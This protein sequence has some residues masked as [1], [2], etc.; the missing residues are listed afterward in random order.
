MPV[1]D[2]QDNSL[3]QLR[4]MLRNRNLKPQVGDFVVRKD[5][6]HKRIAYL[7]GDEAI[8]LA[9]GGSFYLCD[10]GDA[11]YSGSLD[12]GIPPKLEL[13][14]EVRSGEFWVFH[15]D[16][17]LAH[18]G[19]T[20]SIPCRVYRLLEGAMWK[21]VLT[22]D[23][24]EV[25]IGDRV[26]SWRGNEAVVTGFCPP[27]H[28][29]SMGRICVR[30]GTSALST[31]YFPSVYGCKTVDIAPYTKQICCP[32]CGFEMGWESPDGTNICQMCKAKFTLKLLE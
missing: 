3:V 21:L 1:F 8:Q 28:S 12:P 27:Q 32:Y 22:K 9:D 24:S 2:E 5:G 16:F 23:E 18:N 13:T 20:F 29:G 26:A 7:W 25:K 15:H 31:E 6:H 10:T 19:V 30:E 11:S 4:A 17:V 14:E